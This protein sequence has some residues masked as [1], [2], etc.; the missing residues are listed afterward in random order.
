MPKETKEID[1]KP[2]APLTSALTST[3][4]ALNTVDADPANLPPEKSFHPFSPAPSDEHGQQR[5]V[6]NLTLWVV[7]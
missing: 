1:A 4:L 3:N 2:T 7:H 6:K 5:M